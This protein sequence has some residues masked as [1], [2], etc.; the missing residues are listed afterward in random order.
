MKATGLTFPEPR[1]VLAGLDKPQ[2]LLGP[3]KLE[4]LA[5]L[6]DGLHATETVH[7]GIVDEYE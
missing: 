4:I 6:L 3:S 2:K 1:Y 5:A 7:P